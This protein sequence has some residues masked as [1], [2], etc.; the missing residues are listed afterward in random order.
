MN[1]E[2]WPEVEITLTPGGG[3]YYQAM[4]FHWLV[5][6]VAIPIVLFF[7]IIGLVVELIIRFL[8]IFSLEKVERVV[9]SLS[10]WRNY[11][12]Y[13]IYLGTDPEMWHRLRGDIKE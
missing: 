7:V 2:K 8:S 4:A 9:N 5:V 13:R 3:R 1:S 11:T 10:R 12:K 6:I